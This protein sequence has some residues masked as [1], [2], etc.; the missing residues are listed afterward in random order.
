MRG[1]LTL[2]PLSVGERQ[3]KAKSFARDHRAGEGQNQKLTPDSL[4]PFH[5]VLRSP[6]V[7]GR[8]PPELQSESPPRGLSLDPTA[9]E[10]PRWDVKLVPR[11]PRTPC[12][13]L[14][15]GRTDPPFWI[16]GTSSPGL[17]FLNVQWIMISICGSREK[18]KIKKKKK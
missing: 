7:R 2:P 13:F 12:P 11:F 1:A 6:N 4:D 17:S 14:P 10:G 3:V 18:R 5:E 15:R 9:L 16:P 8:R